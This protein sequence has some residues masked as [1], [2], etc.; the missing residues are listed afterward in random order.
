M[1]ITNDPVKVDSTSQSALQFRGDTF[2]TWRSVFPEPA[3]GPTRTFEDEKATF[4]SMLPMLHSRYPEEYVAIARGAI[5]DHDH[6]RLQLVRRFFSRFNDTPV[7][8]GFVG[9]RDVARIPTPFIRRTR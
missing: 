2:V 8:V 3:L 1:I 6:S 9:A 7:Y 5:A 4:F